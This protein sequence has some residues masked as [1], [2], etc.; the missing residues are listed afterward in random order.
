MSVE[1][2]YPEFEEMKTDALPV[3]YANDNV[4]M[5]YIVMTKNIKL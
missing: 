1:F 2:I 3:G 4:P 5:K